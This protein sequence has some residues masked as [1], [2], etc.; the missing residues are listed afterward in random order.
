MLPVILVDC[1]G[2]VS[3]TLCP[4]ILT[5]AFIFRARSTSTRTAA[6]APFAAKL[7]GSCVAG[8]ATL[9]ARVRWDCIAATNLAPYYLL[10]VCRDAKIV[11][12]AA[13]HAS[14]RIIRV[15]LKS[16]HVIGASI[17]ECRNV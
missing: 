11:R 7:E 12:I 15:C 14:L 4:A 10:L 13:V 9:E 6:A 16:T 1:F 17:A 2:L 8:M 3:S 5:P